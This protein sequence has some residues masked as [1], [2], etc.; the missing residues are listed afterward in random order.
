MYVELLPVAGASVVAN[1]M[2]HM[3]KSR[4]VIV[5]LSV[6]YCSDG[7]N[8]FELDQATAL[9]HDQNYELEDIIVI[10]KG[11]VPARKVP[12]HLYRQMR[13]G[14]FIEW[15]DDENAKEAF[16]GKLIERLQKRPDHEDV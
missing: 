5:V 12:K 13:T 9:L 15:E 11:A 1:V 16:R 3:V 8:E 2:E 7:M 10:K 14:M 6:N 4:K